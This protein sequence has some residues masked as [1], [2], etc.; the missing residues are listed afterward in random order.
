MMPQ[1]QKR[2]EIHF[3]RERHEEVSSLVG[4]GRGFSVMFI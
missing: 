2:Q 1:R 3:L 4:I